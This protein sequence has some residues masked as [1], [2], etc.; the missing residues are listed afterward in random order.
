MH[1]TSPAAIL[2]LLLCSC[3]AG[4]RIHARAL[5]EVH[6]G[7]AYLH[8][9]D[10]ERADVAFTHALAY[11]DEFPEALNGA[12]VVAHQ[13]GDLVLARRRFEQALHA[14]PEF[15]EALVNLGVLELAEGRPERGEDRFRAALR[16]D[17]DLLPARLDLARSLLH[18]G[19]ADPARR[20]RLFGDARREYL[21]LLESH[22]D[23]P[24]ARA[25]LAWLEQAARR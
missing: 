12:G 23:L 11:H 10:L 21:H 2:A 16:I 25:E 9:G 19:R 7:Y 18:R 4:P 13:R 22:P 6:R 1:T 14:A 15:A 5:E 17:P 8:D 24:E 20:E 3:F